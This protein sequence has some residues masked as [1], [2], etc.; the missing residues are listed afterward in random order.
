MRRKHQQLDFTALCLAFYCMHNRQPAIRSCADDEAG[1]L[2]GNVFLH[3]ERGVS[4]FIA[5]LLGWS[6]LPLP[7]LSVVNH[8]V[9]VVDSGV[10]LERAKG[11]ILK[12]HSRLLVA[13]WSG[14]L[15]QSNKIDYHPPE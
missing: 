5:E 2:P 10:D 8:E 15:L 1:T 14:A 3:R 4:E 6:L 9:V 13:L 12:V 11:E 7:N